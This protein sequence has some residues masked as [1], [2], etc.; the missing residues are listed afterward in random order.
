M[1]GPLSRFLFDPQDGTGVEMFY[2]FHVNPWL[3]VMP[4]IQYLRPEAQAI[5]GDS[6]A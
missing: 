6:F 2:N 5:A 1:L 4:N 3:N